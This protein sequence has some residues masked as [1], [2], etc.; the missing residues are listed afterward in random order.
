MR[1]QGLLF[2]LQVRLQ[3]AVSFHVM[4]LFDLN[5]LPTGVAMG[6]ATIEKVGG[7][8]PDLCEGPSWRWPL[9]LVGDVNTMGLG[10]H[11]VCSRW[12]ALFGGGGGGFLGKQ[13]VCCQ[14]RAALGVVWSRGR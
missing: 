8:E 4:F 10:R 11:G 13:D 2:V 9:R 7:C 14:L 1:N 6:V 12:R 5:L 3:K